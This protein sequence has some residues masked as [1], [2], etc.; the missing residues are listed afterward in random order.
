MF[1]IKLKGEKVVLKFN[2][3]LSKLLA[4]L[5]LCTAV[6][7]GAIGCSSAK[8]E[9]KNAKATMVVNNEKIS[10]TVE[11]KIDGDKIFVSLKGTT[12][13]FKGNFKLDGKT[14]TVKIG[15]D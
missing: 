13:Y 7:V 2:K 1:I 9:S 10:S 12:E 14:A 3:R 4:C 8:D 11:T 15:N 6:S 5:A